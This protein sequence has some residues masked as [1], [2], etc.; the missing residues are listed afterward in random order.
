ML[1]VLSWVTLTRIILSL[2]PLH[3]HVK[4]NPGAFQA[5]LLRNHRDRFVLL[6]ADFDTTLSAAPRAPG[7]SELATAMQ[8]RNSAAGYYQV[9]TKAVRLADE[10]DTVYYALELKHYQSTIK[11]LTN[12]TQSQKR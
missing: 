1:T 9:P 8:P 6:S 12:N 4:G 7:P 3:S 2:P 5:N 10:R 11:N